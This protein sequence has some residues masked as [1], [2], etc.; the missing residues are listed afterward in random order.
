MRWALGIEY[1]GSAFSGWQLQAHARSVQGVVQQALS[2][3]ADHPV[4]VV[5]AGRTDSGVH[6]LAQVV[7]FD[8]EAPRRAR[9]WVLGA[10]SRLPRDVSLLWAQEVPAEFHARFSALERGY[11]YVILNRRVR[12]SL[13][14]ERS[15]WELRPLDEARMQSAAD[16]LLGEHDFSAFRAASCQAGTPVR[17]LRTLD[18]A[19]QGSLI[20]IHISA[21]AFLQHMVR[22]IA[23]ALLRVG[24]GEQPPQWVAS[25]L[26]GKDRRLA[27]PTAPAAGLYLQHIRYPAAFGLPRPEPDTLTGW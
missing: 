14:R 18:V 27:A 4:Q 9:S 6:A 15:H 21:N 19:R 13:L 20:H 2:A 17:E 1:D 22:N 8:S 12:S 11:H 7:H 23:G 25:L 5:A 16:L 10:N 26:A 24:A 3:V